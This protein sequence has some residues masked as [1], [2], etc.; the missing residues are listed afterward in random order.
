[1]GLLNK[2]PTERAKGRRDAFYGCEKTRKLPGVV[3]YLYLK[4]STV[5]AVKGQRNVYF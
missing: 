3:T 2:V 1:M 5:K 4:G